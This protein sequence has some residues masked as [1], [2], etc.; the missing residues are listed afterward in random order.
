M[1]NRNGYVQQA[2][3]VCPTETA[4][5]VSASRHR[6]DL[7]NH[8]DPP[9]VVQLPDNVAEGDGELFRTQ[10]WLLHQYSVTSEQDSTDKPS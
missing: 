7:E 3:P 1:Q 2:I 9:Q 8:S 6:A 10:L 4:K 5:P